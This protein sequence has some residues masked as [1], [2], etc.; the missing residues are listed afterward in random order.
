MKIV[1]WNCRG[2]GNRPAVRGLLELQKSEKAEVLFLSETKL[3]RRRIEKFR[4]M[5]GL[6]NMVVYDVVG[7]GG[8]WLCF[9]GEESMCHFAI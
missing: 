2:L 6:S 3:D 5:L 9:G 1:I 7:K 4:W 8:G